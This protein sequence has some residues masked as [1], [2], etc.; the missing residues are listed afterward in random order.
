MACLSLSSSTTIGSG[1]RLVLNRTSSS[2]CRLAG[3]E[4][5]TNSLLLRLKSGNTRRDCAISE[6]DQFLVD[7]VE[8]ETCQVEQ[9][10][11]EGPRREDRELRRRHPLACND[12]LDE[13]D[14]G[15]LRLCLQRLG[16]VLGH[17]TVLREGARETADVAGGGVGGH[18]G[19]KSVRSSG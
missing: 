3:S 14:V 6:V 1:T 16:F 9:R 13:R 18:D 5:A 19:R 11:A 8:I 4:I 7:L 17:D 2:T 12:L 10:I 15:G